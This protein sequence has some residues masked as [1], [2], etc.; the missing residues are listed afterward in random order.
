MDADANLEVDAA[1]RTAVRHMG[2]SYTK[3][4]NSI[5][6]FKSHGHVF[7]QTQCKVVWQ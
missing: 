5:G 7:I 6:F 4:A 3:V 2:S 1:F